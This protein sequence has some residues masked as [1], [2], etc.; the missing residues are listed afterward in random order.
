MAGPISDFV[1]SLSSDG[2]IASQGSV[3][4]AIAKDAGLMEEVKHEEEAIE[5]DENEEAKTDEPRNSKNAQLVVEEE[6]AVGH[7]SW[8]ACE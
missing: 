6:I 5:L 1:V 8:S 2:H 3:R 7:I 4:E